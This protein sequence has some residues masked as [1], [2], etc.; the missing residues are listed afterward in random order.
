MAASSIYVVLP[1]DIG[2]SDPDWMVADGQKVLIDRML[3][4]S[5]NLVAA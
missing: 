5:N 3:D 4:L 1:D 2:G